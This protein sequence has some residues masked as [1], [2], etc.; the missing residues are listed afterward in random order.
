MGSIGEGTETTETNGSLAVLTL[1]INLVYFSSTVVLVTSIVILVRIVFTII[2]IVIINLGVTSPVIINGK[3]YDGTVDAARD[4]GVWENTVL[5]WCKRGYDT[6]GNPCRYAD[7]EQ[8]EY[9][10]HKTSSKAILIDG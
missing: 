8:K 10:V 7:E 1:S 9:T 6:D 4:L 5:N 2:I 3:T